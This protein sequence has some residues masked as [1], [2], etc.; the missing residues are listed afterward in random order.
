MAI[1]NWLLEKAQTKQRDCC[2][3]IET[4]RRKRTVESAV[5]RAGKAASALTQA[6]QALDA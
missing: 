1:C 3:R 6:A 4:L 5:E 2:S